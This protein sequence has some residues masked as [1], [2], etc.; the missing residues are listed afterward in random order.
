MF[1]FR[2]STYIY[3]L[4]AGSLGLGVLSS[5]VLIRRCA[6]LQANFAAIQAQE[7]QHALDARVI[8][9]SFKKQVQEWKDILLRGDNPEDLEKYSKNFHDMAT[10]VQSLTTT[11][12]EQVQDSEAK[13]ILGDFR[14]AHVTMLSRY[15]IALEHFRQTKDAH[16]ADRE[17]KGMDR[18]PT[19]LLDKAVELLNQRA[20]DKFEQEN[21]SASREQSLL[22]V[23]LTIVGLALGLCAW[24]VVNG[25][26]RRLDRTVAYVGLVADG[27]LTAT[28]ADDDRDDELGQLSRVMGKM[29]HSLQE[30]IQRVNGLSENLAGSSEEIAVSA[31]KIAENSNQQR[32]GTAQISTAM[33]EMSVTVQQI[34]D[35]SREAAAHTTHVEE[36]ARDGNAVVQHALESI[37]SLAHS[38]ES[39]CERIGE[40]GNRSAE[41]GKIIDVIDEIADQTNLLALNAA[42]EAARAG[43]QGRGFAVVADEVRKLAERTG[44]ATK[45]ITETISCMQ[46]E[47]RDATEA[48]KSDMTKTEHALEASNQTDKSLQAIVDAT[49]LAQSM[50]RQIA[51]AANEQSS[52]SAEIN[53]SMQGI[54]DMAE[55]SS[56]AAQE[57]SRACHLLAQTAVDLRAVLHY[58][59]T[60]DHG[61][62]RHQ[63][64]PGNLDAFNRNVDESRRRYQ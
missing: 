60:E 61:R 55:N 22:T 31:Q 59:R 26:V 3:L 40:L 24:K 58:F 11:E 9:V 6:T 19:D 53:Q 28:I 34:S 2:V 12:L 39:S 32:A 27:D 10:K 7:V 51:D 62:N 23:G 16:A 38:V 17:V 41:I 21:A 35:G 45:E 36:L 44:R 18:A 5:V 4:L 52:A 43:E 8:Q 15:D 42:I 48:M 46:R 57:A 1:R 37:K 64:R 14:T 30:I 50:T 54:S 49:R 56:M 29:I 20:R 63:S 47:L 33:H 25:I 13:R